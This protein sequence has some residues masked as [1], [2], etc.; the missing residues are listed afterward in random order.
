MTY[1]RKGQAIKNFIRSG[2]TERAR[3]ESKQSSKVTPG[4]VLKEVPGAVAKVGRKIASAVIGVPKVAAAPTVKRGLS[5]INKA[6]G[7]GVVS[8]KE[9]KILSQIRRKR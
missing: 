3:Q 8:D 1:S 9:A 5:T 4:K 2:K 7:R 6:R